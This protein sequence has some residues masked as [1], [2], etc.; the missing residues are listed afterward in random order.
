MKSLFLA[1]A[2]GRNVYS[3]V[4]AILLRCVRSDIR[5]ERMQPRKGLKLDSPTLL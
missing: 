2:E 4:E 3:G 1:K 5:Q